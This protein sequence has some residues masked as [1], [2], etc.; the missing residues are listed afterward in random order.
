MT[1][2]KTDFNILLYRILR[3]LG[4]FYPLSIHADSRAVADSISSLWNLLS[5][6]A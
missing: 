2:I 6:C 3:S 5:T 1:Y 4:V